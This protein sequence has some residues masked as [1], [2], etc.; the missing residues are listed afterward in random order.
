VYLARDLQLGRQVALKIPTFPEHEDSELL[1]RFYRE[2]RSAATLRHSNICPV[3]DVGDVEGE[4]YLT[5]AYIEGRPLSSY[6]NPQNP[7]PERLVVGI[8]RKLASALEHAHRQGI[9]HRDLKPSNIMIDKWN[10]PIVMDFGLAMQIKVDTNRLTQAGMIL[11]TPAYMPPEQVRAEWGKIGPCSDIY[12]LGV[13]MYELLTGD[14]PFDGP[15]D[16]VMA[17]VLT[18]EPPRP[19]EFIPDLDPRLEAACLKM[20]SKE[21]DDRYSSMRD[22]DAAVAV[23]FTSPNKKLQ[24]PRQPRATSAPRHQTVANKAGDTE[25]QGHEESY[26]MVWRNWGVVAFVVAIGLT[27]ATVT[28]YLAGGDE[29]L[30]PKPRLKGAVVSSQNGTEKNGTEK[31]VAAVALP[32]GRVTDARTEGDDLSPPTDSE[33]PVIVPE[34]PSTVAPVLPQIISTATQTFAGHTGAVASVAFSSDG[35]WI[36]SGSRD[37]TVKVW[38]ISMDLPADAGQ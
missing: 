9:V 30:K 5:M 19:S 18:H 20:I 36:V 34:P 6:V 21:I 24:S 22:V 15:V 10:D 31:D 23:Y 38:D 17:Q 26:W 35:K 1:E 11:G 29:T 28:Y 37:Q 33:Q 12:S 16:I 7:L 13:V 2:A 4:H 8:V 27:T 14:I 3:F 32:A 25:S